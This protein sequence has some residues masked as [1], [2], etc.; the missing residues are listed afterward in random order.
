MKNGIKLQEKSEEKRF[1]C[2]G[3]EGGRTTIEACSRAG[4]TE[5]DAG[6]AGHTPKPFAEAGGSRCP[7][8]EPLAWVPPLRGAGDPAGGSGSAVVG[9]AAAAGA[10]R[11]VP[12]AAAG[13]GS[14][15][16]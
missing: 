1:H 5:V 16:P 6:M 13:R 15:F 3:C 2:C 11:R 4:M 8:C 9:C 7:R 12:A 14:A 10:P